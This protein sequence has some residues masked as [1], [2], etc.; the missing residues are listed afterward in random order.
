VEPSE[1]TDR[2]ISPEL[3]LVD[4]ELAARARAALPERP[5]PP[6]PRITI[7]AA[8]PARVGR[9]RSFFIGYVLLGFAAVCAVIVLSVLPRPDRPTFAASPGEVR[10]RTAQR[11]APVTRNPSRTRSLKRPVRRLKRPVRR[12]VAPAPPTRQRTT[13]PE[14]VKA[15]A[16]RTPPSPQ[17]R[18][19]RGPV[20]VPVKPGPSFAWPAIVG[21]RAYEVLFLR[22]A[23]TF[24]KGQTAIPRIRLPARLR[25]TPGVYRW[26]VWPMIASA[27]GL[28]RR[29]PIV[30]S[31]FRV[32]RD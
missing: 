14:T 21:A 11:P 6:V 24:Y 16:R 32:D 17:P 26:V 15:P 25:F 31:T 9:R 8:A 23:K 4:P 12:R 30:D 27:R 22:N 7:E 29:A 13:V 2:T 18:R 10:T 19:R 1:L 3:V 28:Q 5:W 20:S